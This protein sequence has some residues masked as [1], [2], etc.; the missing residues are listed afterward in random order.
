MLRA[1]GDDEWG[2]SSRCAGWSVQDVVAHVVGVNAFWQA[3]V[4]AGTA[5]KPTR[6]LTGF[7]PA[8]TPPLMVAPMREL[9]PGRSSTS[10]SRRTTG[11]SM[12]SVS[13]TT[14]VG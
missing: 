9:A 11:S 8:A 3:S 1:L 5:G 4:R 12:R 7:D 14:R 10:S 6:I 13:S 2:A